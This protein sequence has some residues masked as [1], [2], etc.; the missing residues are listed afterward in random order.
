MS[1]PTD[2]T[3]P[4]RT[5]T[6]IA[7]L[8]DAT[9]AECRRVKARRALN[10]TEKELADLVADARAN[11]DTILTGDDVRWDDD[12]EHAKARHRCNFSD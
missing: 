5:E 2:I 1:T 3:A 10:A 4:R 12:D 8:S 11:G 9:L 6:P 7:R